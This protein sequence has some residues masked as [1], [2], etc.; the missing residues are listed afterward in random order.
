MKTWALKLWLIAVLAGFATSALA[1]D[2]VGTT[3]AQFLQIGVGARISAMGG[4]GVAAVNGAQSLYWNPARLMESS[5]F[6][7]EV[8]YSNW[9]ADLRHQFVGLSVPVGSS[10]ALGGFAILLGEDEFEQTTLSQQEGNGVMV[11]YG[12]LALGVSLAARLT[13]RFSTGGTVKYIHQKLFSETASSFA[14]D[15][16]TSLRT[17]LRGFT[18]G[19]AMTNLGGEMKLEGRDLMVSGQTGSPIEYQVSE[20]PLPL[21]FQVGAAWKLQGAKE[22]FWKDDDHEFLL[23]FDGQHINEGLTRWRLG[24]KFGVRQ[25]LF[26]RAGRVFGHD[27]E[28]WSVGAGLAANL[29]SYRL[30]VDFAYADLGDLKGV[31]RI[32]IRI[33]GK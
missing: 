29:L 27:T 31:Q 23:C 4:A 22:A 17:D 26:L 10:L 20:W 25:T 5:T 13:D 24:G 15:L 18:I 33:S 19:M 14:I 7:V 1:F 21:S 3:A 16:G 32:S 11:D 12:D 9:I 30:A 6:D 28:T 2:K 8:Y